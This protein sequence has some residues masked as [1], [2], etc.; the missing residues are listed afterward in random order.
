M[1]RSSTAREGALVLALALA[2]CVFAPLRTAI[3]LY[4]NSFLCSQLQSLV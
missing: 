2:A 4:A 1:P 3:V